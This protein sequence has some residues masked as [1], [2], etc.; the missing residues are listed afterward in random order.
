MI[1]RRSDDL[2]ASLARTGLAP[3][4]FFAAVV[5]RDTTIAGIAT[6][7]VVRIDKLQY[8]P[9]LHQNRFT[10]RRFEH[11]CMLAIF[12]KVKFRPV[13]GPEEAISTVQAEA[14]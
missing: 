1:I 12:G 2:R 11:M 8:R 9:I 10:S 13:S 3:R 5:L 6:V 14:T 7:A 4:A